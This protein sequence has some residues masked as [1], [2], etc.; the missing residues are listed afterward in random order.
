MRGLERRAEMVTS[1]QQVYDIIKNAEPK[2]VAVA[3]AADAH[4]LQAVCGAYKEG[5][6]VPILIGDPE[7]IRSCAKE[8]GL[9]I[10]AFRIVEADDGQEAVKAVELVHAQEADVVMKGLMQSAT[11]LR[12]ILKRETGIRTPGAVVSAIAVVELRMLR[13]LAFITDLAITPEPDL[14]TKRKI[15]E[16]AVNVAHKFGMEKPNVAVLCAAENV[17][18]KMAAS[19]DAAALQ[20]MCEE[21]EIEGCCVAG[22]ISFDLAMSEEACEE[23]GYHHEVGG[24]ADILLAPDINAGNIMYKTMMLFADMDTGGIIAGT[25]APVV[26]T[27]RADSPR[28]K[29]N[30]LAM[31]VYLA[32]KE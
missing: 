30:T 25:N 4:V 13:R 3:Q 9:D 22:P 15:M 2:R 11:F 24:K 8:N 19:R 28:T 14:E 1:I 16:N 6:A 12:A 32:G 26:F 5:Y 20:R 29:Q 7:R 10:S 23:K 31:A 21:G 27:S 17:N 18:E